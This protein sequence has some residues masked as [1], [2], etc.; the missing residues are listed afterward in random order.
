M[1]PPKRNHSGRS[2]GLLARHLD[3]VQGS[4]AELLANP[5]IRAAYLEGG[6]PTAKPV[7]EDGASGK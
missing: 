2:D 3:D 5:Q 7:G 1:P 6:Q 4:G